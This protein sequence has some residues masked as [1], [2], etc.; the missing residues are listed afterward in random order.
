M[1][2]QAMARVL[3][4]NTNHSH[5]PADGRNDARHGKRSS[6]TN[7]CGDRHKC[8]VGRESKWVGRRKVGWRTTGIDQEA[9]QAMTPTRHAL[10]GTS[11]RQLGDTSP[12]VFILLS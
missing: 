10:P 12:Q 6:G 7:K 11:T 5:R 9:S 3:G 8:L 2:Y 1:K 4:T